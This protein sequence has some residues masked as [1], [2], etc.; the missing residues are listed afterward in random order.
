MS[1]LHVTTEQLE[2][3][4]LRIFADGRCVPEKCWLEHYHDYH[5]FLRAVYATEFGNECADRMLELRAVLKKLYGAKT[6]VAIVVH[7]EDATWAEFAAHRLNV[8]L[9]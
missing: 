6:D 2:D 7:L 8:H 3:E 4:F 9:A 1:L 5:T